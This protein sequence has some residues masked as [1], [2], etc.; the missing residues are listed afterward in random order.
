MKT[1]TIAL[2]MFILSLSY[3]FMETRYFGYNY[4]P[5]TDA[6]VIADG[7]SFILLFMTGFMFSKK[8]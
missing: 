6:E 5:Q 7:I 3:S 2:F 4:T 1:K 8:D